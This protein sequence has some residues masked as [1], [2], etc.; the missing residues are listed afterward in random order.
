M[1]RRQRKRVPPAII[2]G[3]S[4]QSATPQPTAAVPLGWETDGSETLPPGR[5]FFSSGVQ[6][7]PAATSTRTEPAA[8]Q[9]QGEQALP[10]A[11]ASGAPPTVPP[12]AGDAPGASPPDPSAT[13]GGAGAFHADAKVVR[14]EPPNA[15]P[16]TQ[17]APSRIEADYI[18]LFCLAIS[19]ERMARNE[20]D[21]L[22]GE[23]PNDPH[24]IEDNKKRCDLLSILAD[25]F[26]RIA[27]ALAEYSERPQPLLRGKAKQ[28]ADEVGAQLKAWWKINAA[29]ATDW[30]I[31][32][33]ILSASLGA[34]GLVGADMS[35]A[36]PVVGVLI[37]GQKAATVIKATIKRKK[38][39]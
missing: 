2:P 8:G 39:R 3:P 28:I 13:L 23:R 34:L 33:P 37:G 10:T 5:R 36:T 26:S 6:T 22:S 21:R 29:E 15:G 9:W 18:N 11:T 1:A 32:L 17:R 35:F 12:S 20:I 7:P 30:C 25:G 16:V 14:P 4:D 24:T 31:R 38:R 27:A 19:L